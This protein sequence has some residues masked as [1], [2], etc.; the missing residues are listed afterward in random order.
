MYDGVNVLLKNRSEL[1]KYFAPEIPG[2][3]KS[4]EH[5]HG[6]FSPSH[7]H[8]NWRFN[9]IY[10]EQKKIV[11]SKWKITIKSPINIKIHL[12]F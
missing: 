6:D 10:E 12:C 11:E 5:V 8:H 7:L 1:G 2:T 4:A 3:K 9:N